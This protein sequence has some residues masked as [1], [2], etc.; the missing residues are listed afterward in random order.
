MQLVGASFLTVRVPF[1]I[2][3]AVQGFV[4]GLLGG[5]ILWA[6]RSVLANSVERMST[7]IKVPPIPAGVIGLLCIG[8]AV[9]GLLCSMVAVR[10]PL[11][12]R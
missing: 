3:G 11:R 8:G 7:F 12:Y 4:G 6:C 5:V 10:A 9:Y 1:Y 2:E